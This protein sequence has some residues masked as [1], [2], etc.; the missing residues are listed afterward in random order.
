MAIRFTCKCGKSLEVDNILG[1]HDVRCPACSATVRAPKASQSQATRLEETPVEHIKARIAEGLERDQLTTKVLVV[2]AGWLALLLAAMFIGAFM[3]HSTI[4]MWL[5][6]WV[7][8]IGMLECGA[9]LAL[10]GSRW[11]RPIL[12]GGA[13]IAV[14]VSWTYL[15]LGVASFGG[16]FPTPTL[17]AITFMCSFVNL[18]V[19]MGV[20]WYFGRNYLA[21]LVG[22][23]DESPQTPDSAKDTKPQ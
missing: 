1:G 20:L 23:D 11:G 16:E 2:V 4:I 8:L 6:I 21:L 5:F 22:S 7:P 12:V 18:L 19:C 9:Y 3:E 13:L 15:L 17:A 14:G 10:T